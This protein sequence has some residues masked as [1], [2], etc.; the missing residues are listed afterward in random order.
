MYKLFLSAIALIFLAGCSVGSKVIPDQPRLSFG[1]KCADTGEG[2]VAYSYLWIYGK[3][4]GLKAD[5]E[6]C[7]KL[8]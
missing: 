8:K 4:E 7:E 6:T 1:K 5:K 3:E 2:H